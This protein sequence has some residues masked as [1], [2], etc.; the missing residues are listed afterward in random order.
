MDYL[1]KETVRNRI[2]F[3]VPDLE[4]LSPN[5]LTDSIRVDTIYKYEYVDKTKQTKIQLITKYW[6]QKI[7]LLLCEK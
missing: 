4:A 2:K 1:G 3:R 7:A 5:L 6:G